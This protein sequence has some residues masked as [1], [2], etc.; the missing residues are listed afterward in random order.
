MSVFLD[1][2]L[3]DDLTRWP[4]YLKPPDAPE[5]VPISICLGDGLLY[6]GTEVLHYRPPLVDGHSTHWFLFWVPESFEGSLD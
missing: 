6:F 4:I 3:A 1:H 2:P 5:A